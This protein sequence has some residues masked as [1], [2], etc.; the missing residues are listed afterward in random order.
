YLAALAREVH[1][2]DVSQEML[3][4]ARERY[5]SVRYERRDLRDLDALAD[6]GFGAIVAGFGVLDVLDDEGRRAALT[7]FRRLLEPDGRLLFSAHNRGAA[8]HR[9]K[10]TD[11]RVRDPA[12]FAYDL[13]KLP[14]RVRN[15]R[16][17]R[18]HEVERPDY[19]I[20]NDMS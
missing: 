19:A 6:G 13:L 2:T 8:A 3:D 17:R 11:L 12:R 1:A 10:P 16:S 7:E 4:A 5:P 9:E 15:A 20:L 18:E 14:K